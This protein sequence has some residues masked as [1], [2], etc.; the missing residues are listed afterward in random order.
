MKKHK[1][2]TV[3]IIA[4][5]V[6]AGGSYAAYANFF[7]PAAETSEQPELQTAQ[8]RRGDLVLT[9]EGTGMLIPAE[10]VELGFSV[11]G[12]LVETLVEVGNRVQAGDVLARL[13]E[14]DARK[15]AADAELGVA[16]A[17]AALAEQ[18]D[19][20][21][22]EQAVAQAEIQVAQA[23]ASLASAQLNLE[24][25]LTWTPDESEVKL[26]QANLE[27]AW[28]DYNQVAALG[29][30]T[31]DQL[32]QARVN[33]ENAQSQL[34]YAQAAY[35][36]A[37]DPGRDWELLY[38]EPT[39]TYGPGGEQVPTGITK[40][41]E[42]ENERAST[43]RQVESA[44]R[45]LDAA[46][47]TYNLA[48]TEADNDT[49]LASAWSKV[50]SAQVSLEQAQ[51]GPS[52]SEVEA[53]R[54]QVDQ[55][56]LSLTQ[57]QLSLEAAQSDLETWDTTPA[58]LSLTQAQLNLEAAQRQLG[59]MALIAPLSGTVMAVEAQVGESVGTTPI[60]SLADLEMPQVLFWVEESDLMS[61][62]PGNA[63]N[64]VFEALPDYT[65]PGEVVSVDPALVTVDGTPAVQVWASVDLTAHPVSILSG[66]NA[67]VEIVAAEA[68]NALLVP[69]QALRELGPGQYAVFVV[70][71]DGE[72]EMR[73]VEVGLKDYV[74][75]EITSGLEDGEVVSTGAVESSNTSTAPSN[76]D[77][78]PPS[79]NTS[80]APSNG[81]EAPPNMMR[82]LGG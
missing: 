17:E 33:L 35:D 47:A 55:A 28:A 45:N 34:V 50:V 63:V 71:A 62:A 54:L 2:W 12:T 48:V 14:A 69:I 67:E 78:A 20:T 13:D 21:A 18:Q 37:W 23:E 61:V 68:R 51:T 31:D 38:T 16:Q 30:H 72:L 64:V 59:E 43:R 75:A 4:M 70:G 77:E 19:T 3:L 36:Q 65:F 73:P 44:Q 58:E 80:T 24:E 60:V 5:L 53:V 42:L 32:T 9:A 7:I 49:G 40:A 26:A 66:M 79:S 22:A 74:N 6:V 81:D 25:L 82:F 10:E 8:V 76:G 11:G 15:A 57:A 46:Q 56:E 1:I 41:Q 27:A 29:E 52:E 39:W